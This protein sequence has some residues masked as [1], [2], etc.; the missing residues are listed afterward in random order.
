LLARA[1]RSVLF[2]EQFALVMFIG[3]DICVEFEELSDAEID[4]LVGEL[5]GVD[6]AIVVD[7][8]LLGDHHFHLLDFLLH[9]NIPIKINYKGL[10]RQGI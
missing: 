10:R 5:E 8:L 1:E 4:A 6:V 3:G 7:L 2:D 9:P